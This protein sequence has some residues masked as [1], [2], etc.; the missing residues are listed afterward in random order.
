MSDILRPIGVIARAL[1]SISNI[2]FKEVDLTRGQYLY[3]VRI[4]ENPGIILE[5][6]A[7][8][9]KVDKTTA[10]RAVQK[11]EKNG[12]IERRS[13]ATNKKIRLLFPTYKGKRVYPFIAR[14]NEYSNSVALR[15]LSDTEQ[16][17]L[18]DLLLKVET[19]ISNDWEYVKSGHKRDY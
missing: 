11:L 1:D 6:L 9:I 14:E 16:E 2:E 13:D 4:C 17:Q 19:N 10:A 8:L 3:L 18:F 12:M 7:N 5:Q 15:G